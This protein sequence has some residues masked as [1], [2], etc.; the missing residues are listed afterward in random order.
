M[1]DAVNRQTAEWLGISSAE[2]CGRRIGDV[3]PEEGQRLAALYRVC[4]ETGKTQR[5]E[6]TLVGT[7][8]GSTFL[9]TLIPVLDEQG[10]VRRIVGVARDITDQKQAARALFE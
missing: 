5:R 3:L 10:R 9:T 4:V 1:I 7:K 6:Q 2:A 8:P